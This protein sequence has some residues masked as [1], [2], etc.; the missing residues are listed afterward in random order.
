MITTARGRHDPFAQW[1]TNELRE[2]H[3]KYVV[4]GILREMGENKW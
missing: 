3:N 2:K 1:L 4:A